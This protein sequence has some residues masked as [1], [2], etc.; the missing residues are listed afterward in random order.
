MKLTSLFFSSGASASTAMSTPTALGSRIL[1]QRTSR[2]CVLPGTAHLCLTARPRM[3]A[4][5]MTA[6]PRSAVMGEDVLL[7]PAGDVEQCARRQEIETGLGERHPTLTLEPLVKFVL[8]RVEV[9]HVARRIIPL[10]IGQLVRAPIAG[11]LL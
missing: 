4:S 3:A 6:Y 9:A 7:G 11:L 5:D 1:V 10:R 8:Q 2:S